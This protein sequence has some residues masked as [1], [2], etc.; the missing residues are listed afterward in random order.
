MPDDLTALAV[1]P[2]AADFE[3][4]RRLSVTIH[5]R[6]S[7]PDGDGAAYRLIFPVERVG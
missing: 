5:T 1:R 4:T 6:Q 3:W 2:L 7:T